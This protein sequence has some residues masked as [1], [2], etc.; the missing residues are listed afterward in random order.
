[1]RPIKLRTEALSRSSVLHVRTAGLPKSREAH[2][3]GTTIV[4][5]GRES[6]LQGEGGQVS[7][8]PY[9]GGMRNAESRNRRGSPP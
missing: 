4:V 8:I 2:G 7:L 1:M 6:R 9:R 5:S 3:N